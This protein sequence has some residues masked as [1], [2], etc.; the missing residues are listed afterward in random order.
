MLT[1]TR[2]QP[3]IKVH[4]TPIYVNS[5]FSFPMGSS[6][7]CIVFLF[8]VPA[9]KHKPKLHSTP[10]FYPSSAALSPCW[11]CVFHTSDEF[12][13]PAL[14]TQILSLGLGCQ[15]ELSL[16]SASFFLPEK[17]QWTHQARLESLQTWLLKYK[18]CFSELESKWC[19]TY[20]KAKSITYK[21]HPHWI[22][23]K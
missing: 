16:S 7:W 13:Y 5:H 2:P 6:H 18:F 8:S 14:W 3:V 22:Y 11:P 12:P 19:G 21:M 17:A 1:N 20:I 23:R 10:L 4:S 15:G 9:V